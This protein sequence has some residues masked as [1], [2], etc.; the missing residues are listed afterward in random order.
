MVTCV[1]ARVRMPDLRKTLRSSFCMSYTLKTLEDRCGEFS[2]NMTSLPLDQTMPSWT[3]TDPWL[4]D[5]DRTL[6]E[7]SSKLSSPSPLNR[8]PLGA[9]GS[10]PT[11]TSNHDSGP[12]KEFRHIHARSHP[13][14]HP[15]Y[16]PVKGMGNSKG[17]RPSKTPNVE[18]TA[19]RTV[20]VCGCV[21]PCAPELMHV[22]T[23]DPL[24]TVG[25]GVQMGAPR[26]QD[27][28]TTW[29][30]LTGNR[31]DKRTMKARPLGL[32]HGPWAM[33]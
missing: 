18:T 3:F 24:F 11:P 21:R 29:C 22:F 1:G 13:P 4:S 20:P 5:C 10:S 27:N 26:V 2:V 16:F 9:T 14:L 31:P 6:S 7:S 15:E 12:I 25:F 17:P 8:E 33:G 23:L 28:Y 32:G 19:S 30:A